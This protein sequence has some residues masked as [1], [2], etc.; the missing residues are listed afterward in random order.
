M[1]FSKNALYVMSMG[2]LLCGSATIVD[3]SRRIERVNS[4][5][6]LP[7]STEIR[8]RMPI[9]EYIQLAN[10]FSDANGTTYRFGDVMKRE[11]NRYIDRIRKLGD[12]FGYKKYTVEGAGDQ[13]EVIS[14][15]VSYP[16]LERVIKKHIESHVDGWEQIQEEYPD[17]QF[18]STP[19]QLK[20]LL[21]KIDE[22]RDRATHS[23]TDDEINWFVQA[24]VAD[25]SSRVFQVVGVKL[26][27]P[28]P[29]DT[30]RF[31]NTLKNILKNES[32][33]QR[34]MSLLLIRVCEPMR[35][36]PFK[37]NMPESIKH[38][39]VLYSNQ[40]RSQ[41]RD[42]GIIFNEA[43]PDTDKLKD[44]EIKFDPI[45]FEEDVS[46]YHE[47]TH[48]YHFMIGSRGH[49]EGELYSW[50]FNFSAI[51]SDKLDLID[52]FYP[53]LKPENMDPIIEELRKLVKMRGKQAILGST[54]DSKNLDHIKYRIQAIIR[55]GFGN[56]LFK[57]FSK[58]DDLKYENLINKFLPEI[59][60]LGQLVLNC[61]GDGIWDDFEEK[62]TMQGNNIFLSKGR[63]FM[64][65][66]RQHEQIYTVRKDNPTENTD[67][68]THYY[69]H[70][71]FAPLNVYN[72]I[73]KSLGEQR[74][75]WFLAL[76]SKLWPKEEAPKEE[77]PTVK[78]LKSLLMDKK[79]WEPSQPRIKYRV[80]PN[81]K[82]LSE[83]EFIYDNEDY[84][85]TSFGLLDAR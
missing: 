75:N 78:R 65:E 61:G 83:D 85:P 54:A 21:K 48:A 81:G 19:N 10:K 80:T 60:Y 62:I 14:I 7:Q 44:N 3:A 33:F 1:R 4:T 71:I 23:L 43:L 27:S 42:Y 30:E 15:D 46:M 77:D 55:C 34:L 76:L 82:P 66:D 36:L 58:K 74:M 63:Y 53:M 37:N 12:I 49:D 17:T 59:L 11:Y 67:I 31:K 16:N 50:I 52:T 51:N 41:F 73:I 38:I 72:L 25:D 79:L 68:H 40:L 39:R 24:L 69:S 5:V 26:S 22:I 56:F 84:K 18:P 9:E 6:I 47:M 64:V 13:P 57:S 28:K 20:W 35:L 29:G 8:E 70:N 2:M 32:G 45:E